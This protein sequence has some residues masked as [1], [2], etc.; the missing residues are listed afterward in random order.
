MNTIV[1]IDSDK[2]I[3]C[4]ACVEIC[5]NKILYIKDNVCQV[6]D[7]KKCDK[8]RGCERVCPTEAIKIQ[9]NS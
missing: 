7:E 9:E 3:G 4:G 1:K 2:C 6:S 5:P 8:S